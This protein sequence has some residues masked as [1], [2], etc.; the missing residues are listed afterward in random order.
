MGR[1]RKS[2]T[3]KAYVV[4]VSLPNELVALLDL[5][6]EE[7]GVSRSKALAEILMVRQPS[8]ANVMSFEDWFT[9]AGGEL[10]RGSHE[11]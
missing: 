11:L 7:Y 6:A 5:Y 8:G 9:F 1:P 2:P 3:T 4:S 10:H